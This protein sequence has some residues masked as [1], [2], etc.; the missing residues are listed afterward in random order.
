MERME[1]MEHKKKQYNYSLHFF[2]RV[3]VLIVVSSWLKGWSEDF[4]GGGGKI[5]MVEVEGFEPST[6]ALPA[7]CSPTELYPH[8]S[9]EGNSIMHNPPP[10]RQRLFLKGL[11]IAEAFS[12]EAFLVSI[13]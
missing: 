1:N 9:Y 10:M 5:K 12:E 7:Q 2:L 6:P 3:V 11:E 4:P 8:A 13:R